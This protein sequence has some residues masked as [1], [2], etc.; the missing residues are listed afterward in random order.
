MTRALRSSFAAVARA[1][2]LYNAKRVVPY[3]LALLFGANAAL[4]WYGGPAVARGWATNSDFY[5]VRSFVGFAFLT[6]PL[7]TALL[8]GDPVLRDYRLGIDGL[9][10]STP[11][12]RAGYLLGKFVGNFAVLAACQSVFALTMLALQAFAPERMVVLPVRVAPYVVYFLVYVAVSHVVLAAFCFAVGTLTRSVRLVYGLVVCSYVAYGAWMQPVKHLAP[13]YRLA[14]D[15]LLTGWMGEVARGR[16]AEWL[17]QLSVG[18]DPVLVAN[19]AAML[20]VAA[21]CLAVVY[22]RFSRVERPRGTGPSP[23]LSIASAAP[24]SGAATLG[25]APMQPAEVAPEGWRRSTAQMAGALAAEAR[26]LASERGLVVLVPAVAILSVFAVGG[27]EPSLG[28]SYSSEYAA[29]A[30]S[31]VL[32]FLF[33]A[34]VFYTGEAMHRDRELRVEALVSSAPVRDA[35]L[36]LPKATAV[37]AVC[38]CVTALGA[39]GAGAAQLLRGNGPIDVISYVET[40]AVISVPSAVFMISVAVLLNAVFR[41]KYVAFALGLGL[42]GLAFFLF[43]MGYTHWAYN[44]VL[45]GVGTQSELAARGRGPAPLFA[46]RIYCLAVACLCLSLA[47]MALERGARRAGVSRMACIAALASAVA[48]VVAGLVVATAL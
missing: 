12:T 13:A 38:V 10:L 32:L 34:A 15:P 3:A 36:L 33:G 31:S 26:L 28:V 17:N 39:L 19:R 41:D 21:G 35:V 16:S 27:P 1:E 11:V 4:W 14:L 46:H 8:M 23:S 48:A 37:L 42:G 44:F 20:L 6:S 30:A 43:S 25:D 7:C 22:A 18:S 5:I 45:L 2:V 29:R 24:S 9:V 47:H 40:L